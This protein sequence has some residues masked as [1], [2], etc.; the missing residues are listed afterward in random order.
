MIVQEDDTIAFIDFGAVG[1]IDDELKKN[2]LEFYYAINN[3]DVEG[4]MQSF[5]NIGGAD[6]KNVDVAGS[7]KILIP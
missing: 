7:G 4:A 5:L 2:I 6:A 1:S 3:K